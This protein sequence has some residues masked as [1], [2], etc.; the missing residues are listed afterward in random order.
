M[1][2][3]IF[4]ILIHLTFQAYTILIFIRIVGS[5]FPSIQRYRLIHFT[6]YY[7]DPYLNIFR[8]L[9]PPLGGVLDISPILGFFALEI[10]ER[11]LVS[12]FHFIF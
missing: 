7:T 4:F 10:M 2:S 9:I 11:M 12:F 1:F 8:R 3:K 6:R 5:W